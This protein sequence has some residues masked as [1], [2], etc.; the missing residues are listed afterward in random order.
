MR[1]QRAGY[2]G[3]VEN[4][5]L[6]ISA[7]RE[8]SDFDDGIGELTHDTDEDLDDCGS[9]WASAQRSSSERAVRSGAT[10]FVGA[11]AGD[12][13]VGIGD[14]DDARAERNIFCGEGVRDSRSRRKIRGGE[15]HFANAGERNERFEKF[16]RR[17]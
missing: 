11:V 8:G 3:E 2:G 16:W 7:L 6:A 12:G 4:W 1:S 17:R 15:N 14:G 10:F 9:N 13:V 5:E